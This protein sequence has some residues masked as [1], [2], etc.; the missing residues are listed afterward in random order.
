[1]IIP[2]TNH[3]LAVKIGLLPPIGNFYFQ[4][5]VVQWTE[6]QTSNLDM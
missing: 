3:T 6:H 2:L 5:P 4:A 1:M